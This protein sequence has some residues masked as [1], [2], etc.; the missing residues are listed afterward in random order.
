MY[1]QWY[2][3]KNGNSYGQSHIIS[4]DKWTELDLIMK[5]IEQETVLLEAKKADYMKTT[6][7]MPHEEYYAYIEQR[8]SAMDK[9]RAKSWII[10]HKISRAAYHSVSG[11]SES[12]V[13]IK[14]FPDAGIASVLGYLG[15]GQLKVDVN[16]NN[17]KLRLDDQSRTYELLVGGYRSNPLRV[18]DT[19]CSF[20]E[21]K[22][23]ATITSPFEGAR[24][25]EWIIEIDPTYT[26]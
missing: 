25:L 6:P 17:A 3:E 11:S 18:L 23:Y 15:C 14:A 8:H 1:T 2:S 7:C 16:S 26:R 20:S 9:L 10:A 22:L 13:H 19:S 5:A 24:K 4:G 21:T 12:S